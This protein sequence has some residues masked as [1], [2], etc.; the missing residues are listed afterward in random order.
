MMAASRDAAGVAQ[1][2]DRLALAAERTLQ[3]LGDARVGL[4]LLLLTGLAN[5]A[6][7]L[8]PDGPGRLDGWPYALLL[9]AL[10]LSSVAAVSVRIP[11]TWREWRHPGAVGGNGLRAVV[12]SRAPEEVEATLRAAGYRTRVTGAPGSRRWAVHGVRRGW[13]RFAAQASHLGLVVVVL[14][15]AVG[16]AYGSETTFSLL[17][18]DQAL[19]D[20]PRPGF[21]SAV[22][23]DAFAAEFDADGRPQRLDTEV[24]FLRDGAFAESSL[25]RVNEPGAFDGY[26]V[27]PWTYG[28]AA[29]IRVTTVGGS[30]LL[31]AAVPL[32]GVQNGIPVGSVELPTAGVTLGLALADATTNQLGASVVGASGL[33]DAAQIRPGEQARIG[34]VV[35]ELERF[36]AWVTFLSRRDPGL[37]ILFAGAGLLCASLAVGFWLPRR[38]VTVRPGRTGLAISVRGERFDD[39]RAELDRLVSGLGGRLVSGL[40]GRS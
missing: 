23:L 33:A 7:A 37:G 29:R 32:D 9:G 19:L 31:H 34:D 24:T 11:A 28:P 21:S 1:R 36:D 14:G 22:R 39:P 12:T 20:G 15:A 30:A 40:G 16:A 25:L 4:I 35:L 38:R 17:P 2:S 27:H 6:G 8:L 13:S 5:V 3:R 26:L 10:A 18:G